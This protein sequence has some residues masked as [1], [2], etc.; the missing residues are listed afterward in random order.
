[1]A[2]RKAKPAIENEIAPK[3]FP[4]EVKILKEAVD[5]WVEKFGF[6][7]RRKV[8]EEAEREPKKDV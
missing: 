2:K 8:A 7:V 4:S 3:A 1:M 6:R 5:N